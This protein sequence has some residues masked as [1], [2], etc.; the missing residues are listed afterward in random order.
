MEEGP[1]EWN[2]AQRR[3]G[4][5]VEVEVLRNKLWYSDKRLMPAPMAHMLGPVVLIREEAENATRLLIVVAVQEAA[6]TQLEVVVVVVWIARFGVP[7]VE[8][9]LGQ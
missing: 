8:E 6:Y 1:G 9:I 3:I 5:G 7:Y 2:L 4:L